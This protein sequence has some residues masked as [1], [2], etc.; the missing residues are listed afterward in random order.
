MAPQP[1]IR[2]LTALAVSVLL[3]G[4]RTTVA[5]AQTLPMGDNQ[6]MTLI[7]A[8]RD[9]SAPDWIQEGT[10][11]TYEVAS[12]RVAGDQLNILGDIGVCRPDETGLSGHGFLQCGIVAH[13][14]DQVVSFLSN[15]L[16]D[17]ASG[18]LTPSAAGVAVDNPGCGTLWCNPKAFIGATKLHGQGLTVMKLPTVIGDKTF[19][20]IAFRYTSP[21]AVMTWIYDLET[22]V[23]LSYSH[24]ILVEGNTATQLA[25]MRLRS[26]RQVKMPARATAAPA[27]TKHLTTLRFEGSM[28][29]HIPD[30]PVMPLPASEQVKRTAS[31]SKWTRYTATLAVQGQQGGEADLV[32]GVACLCGGFWTAPELLATYQPGQVLDTDPVT[33]IRLTVDDVAEAG[34]DAQ[35]TVSSAG[36]GFKNTFVY[37]RQTGGLLSMTAAQ[38]IGVA[39]QVTTLRMVGG[40]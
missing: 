30:S 34:D 23:M 39:T 25:V 35:V 14:P 22:G 27:W 3:Y 16:I 4:P 9:M 13:T 28:E 2:I 24:T 15:I 19:Q 1:L 31:G 12:A 32:S 29:V 6:L 5:H 11:V 20:G 18:N 37:S 38:Q 10:V 8:V 21:T 33:G 40:E 17:D 36:N 7:P 26:G